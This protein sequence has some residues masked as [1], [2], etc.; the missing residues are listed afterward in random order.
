MPLPRKERR[1]GTTPGDLRTDELS[2]DDDDDPPGVCT[3][4][5]SETEVVPPSNVPIELTRVTGECGVA[6]L[7][8]RDLMT[9]FTSGEI[10]ERLEAAN[11]E[12]TTVAVEVCRVVQDVVEISENN[13]GTGV[14]RHVKIARSTV[15]FD[16][17]HIPAVVAAL[18]TPLASVKAERLLESVGGVGKVRLIPEKSKSRAF[19]NL[20][21]DDRLELWLK[22]DGSVAVTHVRGCTVETLGRVGAARAQVFRQLA[23]AETELGSRKGAKKPETVERAD[24]RPCIKN[25]LPN[26]RSGRSFRFVLGSGAGARAHYFWLRDVDLVIGQKNLNAFAAAMRNP[27]TLETAT[28]LTA[29]ELAALAMAAPALAEIALA[30]CAHA[31][32]VFPDPKTLVTSIAGLVRDVSVFARAKGKREIRPAKTDREKTVTVESVKKKSEPVEKKVL[33]IQPKSDDPTP[34]RPAAKPPVLVCLHPPSGTRVTT[35]NI[36]LLFGWTHSTDA[37]DEGETKK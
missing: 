9:H 8:A 4:Q 15:R 14:V 22:V 12:S 18:T 1:E 19:A 28:K 31:T 2:E 13:E 23:A 17:A 16:T 35:K 37:D 5:S 21:R 11:R 20:N 30:A 25:P 32:G 6:Q 10:L 26:D 29:N 33:R 3:S 27:P 36:A 7:V 34:K 24:G